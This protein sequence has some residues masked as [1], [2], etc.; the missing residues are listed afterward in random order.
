[1]NTSTKTLF[2]ALI[3][4]AGAAAIGLG[5]ATSVTPSTSPASQ[6]VKLERVVVNGKRAPA[7]VQTAQRVEVLPRVIVEGR[8]VD[9]SVR[10]A[11]AKTCNAETLC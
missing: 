5:L 10:L 8:R 9:D 3:A 1:M 2:T 6:I 11:A 7:T 4:V